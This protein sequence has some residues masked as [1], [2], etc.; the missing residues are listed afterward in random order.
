MAGQKGVP[1]CMKGSKTPGND[2]PRSKLR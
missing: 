2:R 1:P